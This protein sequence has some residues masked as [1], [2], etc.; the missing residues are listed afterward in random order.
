MTDTAPL[1]HSEKIKAGLAKRGKGKQ[2]AAEATPA[3]A[4]DLAGQIAALK[5]I[6]LSDEQI[7]G[8]IVGTNAP[9]GA[10]VTPPAVAQGIAE[11]M[12]EN[13]RK[14]VGPDPA[15]VAAYNERMAHYVPPLLEKEYPVVLP[16]RFAEWLER[17]TIWEG[18]RRNREL[19]PGKMI[20]LLVREA[21]R[22]DEDRQMLQN[23]KT[24]KAGI[25]NP[26][27]GTWNP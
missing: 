3:P 23:T 19:T 24:G 6:G 10:P 1:T 27:T 4:V 26:K 12:A 11:K 2:P 25:F 20:E 9:A 21:W 14:L 15:M 22:M 18:I 5:S 17:K 8:V 13:D 16:I 7:R